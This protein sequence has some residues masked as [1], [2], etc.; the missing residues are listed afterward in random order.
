M[1]AHARGNPFGMETMKKVAI[2]AGAIGVGAAITVIGLALAVD[3]VNGMQ[4]ARVAPAT[5]ATADQ[6]ALLNTG[7]S[8]ANRAKDGATPKVP[9]LTGYKKALA[10]ATVGIVG[11]TALQSFSKGEDIFEI[12]AASVGIGGVGAGVVMGYMGWR[13]NAAR[14]GAGVFA[15]VAQRR[16]A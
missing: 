16:A 8:A 2:S 4:F 1:D 6:I 15:P 10:F 5:G 3:Y 9:F 11:A 7:V 13:A 14:S 12:G